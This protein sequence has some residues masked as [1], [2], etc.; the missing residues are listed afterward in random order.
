MHIYFI[1]AILINLA[2]SPLALAIGSKSDLPQAGAQPNTNLEQDENIVTQLKDVAASAHHLQK[3][4]HEIIFEMT[5]QE[6]VSGS[7]PDVVGAM[8]IPAFPTPTG[9]IATGEFLPPRKKYMDFYSEQA[10]NLFMMLDEEGMSLPDSLAGDDQLNMDLINFKKALSN[11]KIENDALLSAMAG[12]KYDSVS[13]G[14]PAVKMSDDLDQIQ[15]LLKE[16][17]K[18]IH[19]DKQAEK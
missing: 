9:M 7:P 11:L 5:R 2:C 12:P 3:T 8:V 10:R 1:A 19:K 16:C 17:E 18:R 6:Y 15:K 13:I 4:V 14:K